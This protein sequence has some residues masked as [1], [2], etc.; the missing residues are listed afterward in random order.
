MYASLAGSGRAPAE[1]RS[2]KE[3]PGCPRALAEI[4]A[5]CVQRD[6]ERRFASWGELE[7]LLRVVALHQILNPDALEFSPPSSGVR[8]QD[9]KAAP[10]ASGKVVPF[11]REK[12]DTLASVPHATPLERGGS[13]TVIEGEGAAEALRAG[14]SEMSEPAGG[15]AEAVK[16]GAEAVKGGAE[17]EEEARGED[18]PPKS[19]ALPTPRVVGTAAAGLGARVR[20]GLR[21]HRGYAVLAGLALVLVG[22]LLVKGEE[23]VE[24]TSFK[25]PKLSLSEPPPVEPVPVA[26]APEVAPPPREEAPP[27]DRAPVARVRLAIPSAAPVSATPAERP[28]EPQPVPPASVGNA[29]TQFARP[30]GLR[31]EE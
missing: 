18:G 8:G 17:E 28:S 21:E 7:Q 24:A 3:V 26:P 5:K 14:S 13:L 23:P 31:C 30:C 4:V 12:R 25:V 22:A 16:G 20:R 11:E 15:G 1:V 19:D 2:Y 27:R 10:A 9:E 6:P 29:E